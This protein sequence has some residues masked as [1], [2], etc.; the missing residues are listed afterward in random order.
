MDRNRTGWASG[1]SRRFSPAT[2]IRTT[3][4][5]L[6]PPAR[7]VELGGGEEGGA[8]QALHA[9]RDPLLHELVREERRLRRPCS[10][11]RA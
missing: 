5:R 11:S 10:P 4:T 8:S 6:G 1:P 9:Q 2:G 3:R 7:G